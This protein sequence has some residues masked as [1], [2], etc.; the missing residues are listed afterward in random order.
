MDHVKKKIKRKNNYLQR[1]GTH[2]N[3]LPLLRKVRIIL[4]V[5]L[6]LHKSLHFHF[7]SILFVR[8]EWTKLKLLKITRNISAAQ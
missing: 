4:H 3:L 6:K 5:I 8:L 7:E 1:F 2:E